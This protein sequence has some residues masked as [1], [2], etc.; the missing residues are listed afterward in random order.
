MDAP[1]LADLRE[2]VALI[3][4][5]I[6]R[7]RNAYEPNA[8]AVA[9]K[10]PTWPFDWQALLARYQTAKALC[11]GLDPSTMLPDVTPQ[12]ANYEAVARSVQQVA[13][14]RSKG[15]LSDLMARIAK[16]GFPVDESGTP[17]PKRTFND[18]FLEY[19][20]HVPTPGQ[21]VSFTKIAVLAFVAWKV[22]EHVSKK[23]G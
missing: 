18:K 20:N 19:T 4:F 21:L 6:M 17:Q 2:L 1:D 14:T 12:D 7:T 8:V 13:S 23:R 22:I 3:E 10:D 9:M 15:D 5:R 11:V 16:V